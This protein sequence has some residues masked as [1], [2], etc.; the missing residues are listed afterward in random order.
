MN[1]SKV[2]KTR[3]NIDKKYKWELDK[4]FKNDDLWE[5]EFSNIKAESVQIKKFMGKLND[6]EE[7]LEYL[8]ISEKMSRRVEKLYVYAH[9]KSDED[10]ANQK[11]QGLMNKID[12]FMSEF[13][14]YSAFFV[15][16]ILS[17]KEIG[18]ASCRER[19]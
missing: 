18:R 13:G 10:T 15:P 2:I 16:E 17:L 9:M 4:I 6:K 7:I 3:E 11:Y 5:E 1:D 8:K 19:V 14:S 12:I